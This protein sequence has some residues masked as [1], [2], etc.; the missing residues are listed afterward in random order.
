MIFWPE[1][2]INEWNLQFN[3]N[4]DNKNSQ[5]NNSLSLSLPCSRPLPWPMISPSS[6]LSATPLRQT[7]TSVWISSWTALSHSSSPAP[8]AE[9]VRALAGN[10]PNLTQHIRISQSPGWK[11]AAVAE[12][13]SLIT[14][15]R[16]IRQPCRTAKKSSLLTL[17]VKSMILETTLRQSQ[18][19]LSLTIEM[20]N[21]ASDMTY[22]YS[23]CLIYSLKNPF[24][25]STGLIKLF[26]KNYLLTV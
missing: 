5:W 3:K 13:L 19:M 4:K 17:A 2:Y 21:L 15:L 25:S 22:F 23:A 26:I 24:K 12:R 6:C 18:F 7:S 16:P 10:W 9:E 1:P 11:K 20:T 14:S 8:D